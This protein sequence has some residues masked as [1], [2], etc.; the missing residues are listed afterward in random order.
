MRPRSLL[1]K[2]GKLIHLM[3]ADQEDPAEKFELLIQLGGSRSCIGKQFYV[4]GADSV[5]S[6]YVHAVK[7]VVV[8]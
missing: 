2:V 6:Q 7:H 1:Q 3:L 4:L 5:F 8:L